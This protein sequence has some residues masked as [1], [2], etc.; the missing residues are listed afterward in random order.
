MSNRYCVI[1]AAILAASPAPALATAPSLSDHAK[2][3]PAAAPPKS[4]SRQQFM[5]TLQARFNAIDTNH[6]GMIEPAELA[7]AQQKEV[8]QARLVEQRRLDAEFTRLDTNHDGQL[9]KSEFMASAPPLHP[10]NTPQQIIAAMDSNKDGKISV[11]EFEARPLASFEK[12]DTN[13]DG[14]V[15][16]AE[17][18]AARAARQR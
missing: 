14:T 3:A 5:A 12:L 2:A 9:S 8:E 6:D 1:V 16:A 10:R 18:Q 15:T 11:Q 17:I 13:H 4:T 7:A